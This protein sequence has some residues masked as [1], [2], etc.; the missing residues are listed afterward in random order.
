MPPAPAL[1]SRTV[2]AFDTDIE[3]LEAGAGPPLILLQDEETL[4]QESAF[5]AQLAASHRVIIP[6]PPGFGHSERPAWIETPDDLAYIMLDVLDTLGAGRAP[7]M[8]C[9]FGGWLA[10]EMATK[11]C[12]ATPSLVL[13]DPLGIKVGGPA[14]RDIADIWYLPPAQVSALK[15]VTPEAHTIDYKTLPEDRVRV[16][17]RNRE[18]LARF[19]WSPY[20]HNP[21]LRSRLHR[22]TAPTLVLWG[23]SDGIVTPAYGQTYAGTIPGARFQVIDGAGHYPHLE[24]PHAV[25]EAITTFLTPT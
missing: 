3:L 1:T 19:G 14:D 8:G 12:H 25:A 4:T 9:S 13:I 6:S 16:L 24:Q 17:T 22:I 20:L 10:A 7:L 11:T 21:K 23:G 18:S 2:R 5:L 15:Y